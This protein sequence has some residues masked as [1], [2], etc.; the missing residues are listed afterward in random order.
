MGMMS[1]MMGEPEE[2]DNLCNLSWETRLYGFAGC[3]V[4]GIFLSIFGTIQIWFN[5]WTSF[6]LLYT[7]GTITAL[8]STMF[9]RGPQSQLKKMFEKDRIVASIFLMA[10]IVLTI[11]VGAVLQIGWLAII[12][13]IIQSLAFIWYSLS[14]IPFARAAVKSCFGRVTGVECPC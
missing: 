3:L 6:A 2:E 14:Y 8:G 11:V 7:L 13:V 4:I 9:L 5:N 12:C 1:R 10:A